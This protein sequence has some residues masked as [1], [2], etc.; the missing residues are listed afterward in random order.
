MIVGAEEYQDESGHTA[1]RPLAADLETIR[2]FSPAIAEVID[3]VN[4]DDPRSVIHAGRCVAEWHDRQAAW[5]S[6]NS[7]PD[8]SVLVLA[9]RHVYVVLCFHQS[10][11]IGE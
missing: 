8:R 9:L 5:Q 2:A 11:L 6:E 1:L 3:A 10:E 7:T 4:Y